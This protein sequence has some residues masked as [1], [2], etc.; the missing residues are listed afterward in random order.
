MRIAR[1]FVHIP[2]GSF[3]DVAMADGVTMAQ[4]AASWRTD[5]FAMLD[6]IAG[7]YIPYNNIA[8]ACCYDV[9]APTTSGKVL[10][11]SMVPADPN[12]P[13]PAA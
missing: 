11:F 7:P 2:E 5:G 9:D 8:T 4:M 13:E 6:H 10:P 1:I 3:F 12:K